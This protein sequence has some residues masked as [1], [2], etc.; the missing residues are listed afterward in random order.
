MSMHTLKKMKY[1]K[2]INY[3]Y[4]VRTYKKKNKLIFSIVRVQSV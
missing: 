4:T 2:L 3:L 1:L